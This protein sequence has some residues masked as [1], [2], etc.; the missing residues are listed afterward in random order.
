LLFI[1]FGLPCRVLLGEEACSNKGD[2]SF[3][4]MPVSMLEVAHAVVSEGR[5]LVI[6]DYQGARFEN[7][8]SDDD[9]GIG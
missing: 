5:G 7:C 9:L 8:V 3:P 1:P 6:L 2:C 4:D